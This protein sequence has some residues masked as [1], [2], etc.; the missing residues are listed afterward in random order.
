MPV[1]VGRVRVLDERPRGRRAP[2]RE[3]PE[4]PAERAGKAQR[5][6][7]GGE[8]APRARDEPGGDGRGAAEQE[9]HLYD[10]CTI[11]SA[12]LAVIYQKYCK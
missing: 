6:R 8:E 7:G 9:E 12:N 4:A 1:R 10:D 5:A 2:E 3:Q 11:L